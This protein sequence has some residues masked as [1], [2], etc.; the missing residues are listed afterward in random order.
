MGQVCWWTEKARIKSLET[1]GV[2][3]DNAET[4]QVESRPKPLL[5]RCDYTAASQQI[6]KRTGRWGLF[7]RAP[8]LTNNAL[9]RVR[10]PISGCSAPSPLVLPSSVAANAE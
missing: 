6:E 7:D 9:P 10:V 5:R 8:T 2:V 4:G 1:V 3:R